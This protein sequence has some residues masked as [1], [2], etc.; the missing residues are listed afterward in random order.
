[1]IRIL[2]VEDHV[3]FRNALA[4]LLGREPDLEVVT[5]AGSLAEQW[6]QC[7]AW[8]SLQLMRA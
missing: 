3:I 2:L 4:L 5:Q 1:M 7:C 6:I 8:E